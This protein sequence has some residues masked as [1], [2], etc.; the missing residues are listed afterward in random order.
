MGDYKNIALLSAGT[1]I[2]KNTIGSR[3]TKGMSKDEAIL[4]KQRKSTKGIQ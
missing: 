1:G 2:H 3:I 4:F